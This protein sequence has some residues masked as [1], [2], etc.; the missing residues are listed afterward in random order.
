MSAPVIIGISG[1]TGSG[2]STIADAIQEE[3][4]DNITIIMQD[5]YYKNF[6]HHSLEE[7]SKINFDHPETLD[8]ELFIKHIKLLKK[9]VPVEIPIYDFKTHTRTSKTLLKKPSKI[10]ILEGIL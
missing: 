5:S 4:K 6:S 1:G 7:R 8:T 3:V 2:K 9:N 10:I